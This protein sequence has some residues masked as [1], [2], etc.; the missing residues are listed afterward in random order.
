MREFFTSMMQSM[1][2][3][4]GINQV[5]ANNMNLEDVKMLVDLL[6]EESDKW[7]IKDEKKKEIIKSQMMN[8]PKFIGL[9]V[10]AVRNYLSAWHYQFVSNKTSQQIAVSKAHKV[11]T[12][13]ELEQ[14]E[15][16]KK[17]LQEK[18][19]L[20]PSYTPMKAFEAQMKKIGKN[21]KWEKY[22]K[23]E[24]SLIDQYDQTPVESWSPSMEKRYKQALKTIEDCNKKLDK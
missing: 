3:L 18:K 20:D 2:F 21:S 23:I 11:L 7:D 9:N 17:I 4:T 10:K 12:V 16:F 22:I 15:R 6:V 19:A 5:K 14:Q 1:K 8:D 24:Q 13:G